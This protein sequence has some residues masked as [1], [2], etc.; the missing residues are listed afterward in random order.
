MILHYRSI[1]TCFL[2]V[3]LGSMLL[4]IPQSAAQSSYTLYIPMAQTD[5]I[6]ITPFGIETG[7]GVID[8][9]L[10]LEQARKLRAGWIRLNTVSWRA[11]QPTPERDYHWS[12]LVGFEQEL[13]AATEAGLTPIVVVDD[14]PRWATIHPSSCS[15]IQAEY[16]DDFAAFMEELVNRYKEAPYNVHYWEL[17]NEPDVD[18]ALL[19]F[20]DSPFGCWGDASDPY[21]GGEHYGEMLKVV[22]PA[23]KQADPTATVLNGG[24]LLASPQTTTAG[25]G[26]PEKFLEG[27]LRAGAAPYFDMLAY[28]GHSSYDGTQRDYSG[29]NIDSWSEYGGMAIG[30]PAFLR[31]VLQQYNVT[32][33]LFYNEVSLGCPAQNERL[34]TDPPVAFYEAKADHLVRTIIRS[35]Y[36]EVE[37]IIWYT[38]NGPGWRNGGLLDAQQQSRSSYMAYRH[39][40]TRLSLTIDPPTQ[41]NYGDGIEAY[42]FTRGDHVIDVLW[43]VDGQPYQITVPADSLLH[44]YHRDGAAVSVQ[45]T[46]EEAIMQVGFSAMYIERLP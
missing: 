17:G 15:A 2:F 5:R 22:T 11:V 32:K 35:L 29:P 44:A 23:I 13:Q 40:I 16:F 21:Y 26:R 42:R 8:D 20:A 43:S 10:V 14:H 3:C 4:F 25:H 31:E 28:H 39:L 34:C 9:P 38:L 12:A 6:F 19:G 46:S 30:K 18:P 7:N 1:S 24:L 36:V 33:P 37:G 45:S 41:V 27:I